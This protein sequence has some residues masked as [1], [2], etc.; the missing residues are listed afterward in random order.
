[1]QILVLSPPDSGQLVFNSLMLSFLI[2]N[3]RAIMPSLLGGCEIIYTKQLAKRIS[4]IIFWHKLL[5][6]EYFWKFKLIWFKLIRKFFILSLTLLNSGGLKFH[7]FCNWC[8]YRWHKTNEE[9]KMRL[10]RQHSGF[11]SRWRRGKYYVVIVLAS[12]VYNRFS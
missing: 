4:V 9:N 10:C 8:G 6:S 11:N 12:T 1:M 5:T 3:R 2:C 7:Q